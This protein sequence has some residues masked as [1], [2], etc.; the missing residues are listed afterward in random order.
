MTPRL[1]ILRCPRCGGNFVVD[2][3]PE[4][5][6]CINCG[7]DIAPGSEGKIIRGKWSEVVHD[8][9]ALGWEAACRKWRLGKT[10]RKRLKN[11]LKEWDSC[12]EKEQT[13]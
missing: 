10:A 11:E 9:R 13:L 4:Y 7:H 6:G 2:P 3:V 8:G 1:N 5:C 12:Y